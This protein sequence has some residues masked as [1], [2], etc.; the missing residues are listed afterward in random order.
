MYAHVYRNHRVFR[1]VGE[2]QGAELMTPQT[3][4]DVRN[5]K[6]HF[7]RYRKPYNSSPIL[8][9]QLLQLA[10]VPLTLRAIGH[11]VQLTM[12]HRSA[13]DSIF[14]LSEKEVGKRRSLSPYNAALSVLTSEREN[15]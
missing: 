8:L 9:F 6:Q 11:G 5:D 13:T 7:I 14:C 4:N 3:L 12:N 2:T 10:S 15:Y 1:F